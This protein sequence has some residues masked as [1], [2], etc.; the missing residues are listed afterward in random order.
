MIYE[1][2]CCAGQMCYSCM[3][4][5]CMR[6]CATSHQH[7][8]RIGFLGLYALG[9]LLGVIFLYHGEQMMSPWE[10]FGYGKC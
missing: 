1:A 7:H 4:G 6:C 2:W 8:T 10:S 9:V 5:V 3:C